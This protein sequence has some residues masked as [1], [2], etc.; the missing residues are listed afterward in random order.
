MKFGKNG[1]ETFKTGASPDNSGGVTGSP[2][3]LCKFQML[4]MN[5]NLLMKTTG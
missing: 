2:P 3:I 5:H 1:L 4:L